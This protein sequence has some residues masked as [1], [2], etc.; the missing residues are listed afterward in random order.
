[1]S[2]AENLRTVRENIAL[3]CRNAGRAP[4]AV[5]LIAVSKTKPVADLV[6]A[7]AAGQVLFGE[8]YAQELRDKADDGQLA[9]IEWHFIGSLQTNKAKLVAPRASVVHDVDRLDVAVELGKRAMMSPRPLG[10]L[11]GVN[12]GEEPQKSGVRPKEV[13]AF[14]AEVHRLPGVVLRGL[15]CIPPADANPRP[16][17]ERMRAL[18]DRGVSQGLPLR[19]L[20]MGMTH[21]YADAIACGATYVRIGTAIFGAR[22]RAA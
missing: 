1:M 11:I 15:M 12:I 19:E 5:R 20:S 8:N 6:E 3:A 18:A 9:G 4:D 16:H 13:L 14:A 10:V 22:N 17:F 21:D 7:R 2:V